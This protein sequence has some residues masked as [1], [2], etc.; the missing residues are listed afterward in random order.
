MVEIITNLLP[1]GRVYDEPLYP[2]PRR[3]FSNW[4]ENEGFEE[5]LPPTPKLAHNDGVLSKAELKH[6]HNNVVSVRN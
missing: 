5:P 4:L 6:L 2:P 3:G 1:K